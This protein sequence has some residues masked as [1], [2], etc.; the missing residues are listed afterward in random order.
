MITDTIVAPSTP[1]GRAGV[2]M[3]RIS[4]PNSL[5]LTKKLTKNTKKISKRKP[6]FLPVFSKNNDLIDKT[7]ITYFKEPRSY[8]GEDVVEISCH[9]N[10]LIV[11]SIIKTLCFYG[12][13]ISN[14]GEFTMRSFL[15]GKIDLVQA[16]AVSS[17]IESR[18]LASTKAH[19]KI[20]AGSLTEK[21]I[22]IKE[23]VLLAISTI[24]YELDI[25]EENTS[26]KTKL[27]VY[28]TIKNSALEC[29]K[30]L[31]TYKKNKGRFYTKVV[32]CG[33]PNVGKSTL[34]NSLINQEK[35]IVSPE[36]GTT[37]D[38]VEETFEID[39]TPITIIDTAGIRKTQ[40]KIEKEG[41]KKTKEAIKEADILIH[42]VTKNSKLP[43]KI[44]NKTNIVVFNKSDLF[45]KPERFFKANSIS[46]KNGTGINKIKNILENIIIKKNKNTPSVFLTTERQS[47]HIKNCHNLLK[48]TPNKE[49]E[50]TSLDLREALKEIDTLLGKTTNEDIL[51]RVFSNFCVGK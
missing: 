22:K 26:K 44:K 13:R 50:I 31:E 51:N 20:L 17:L 41:V 48:K 2:S 4:G 28:K 40:N 16:E 6:L 33:E 45:K 3:V 12:A 21:L 35:A 23:G 30:L 32:I 39:N 43:K 19:N 47:M 18:S 9:G 46:A 25:S 36:P 5:K 42:V 7:I 34:L 49:P 29:E 27:F 38:R 11:K 37:R 24:E 8:T 10:P 15:N 1:E 14:P